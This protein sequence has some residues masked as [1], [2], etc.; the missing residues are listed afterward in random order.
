MDRQLAALAAAHGV[1]TSYADAGNL[2]VA[3]STETVIGVLGLLDVDATTPDRVADA[4]VAIRSKNDPL[5]LP[6]SIVLT[7][8]SETKSGSARSNPT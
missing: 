6:P 4:L 3:V 5:R 1:A 7:V 8:S 2:R